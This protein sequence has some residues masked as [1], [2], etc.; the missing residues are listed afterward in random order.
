MKT[1]IIYKSKYGSTEQY[2]KWLHEDIED[3]EIVNIKDAKGINLDN[4]ENIIIGSLI[5][6]G[7][8]Q[9]IKFLIEN[10]D[11]LKRKNTYIF[12]VGMA[13][14]DSIDSTLIY[15]TIPEYIREKVKYLKIRGIIN[16][17][18][19]NFIDKLILRMI[20]KSKPELNPDTEKLDR[21]NLKPILTYFKS[22]K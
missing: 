3:S 15:E 10:W 4:F 8:I 6:I 14:N 22:L 18:K 11:I 7:K 5:Y 9:A 20:Q 13:P 2:A 17:S 12:T 19:L 21:N 16:K 1:L